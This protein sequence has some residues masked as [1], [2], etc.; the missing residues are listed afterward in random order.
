MKPASQGWRGIL[1]KSPWILVDRDGT[2]VQRRHYLLSPSDIE[3]I[4]DS[5]DA[6]EELSTLGWNIVIVTNQSPIGRGLLTEREL[7]CIHEC[8]G[9]GLAERNVYPRFF[10]HCP[11]TPEQRCSCRKPK[12]GMFYEA[13]AR[14]LEPGGAWMVGDSSTD[15]LFGRNAGLRTVLL[16]TEGR[17]PTNQATVHVESFYQALPIMIGMT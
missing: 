2:I 16:D 5:L 11:H 14:G 3:F 7:A 4:Q 8:I 6:L 13:K 17:L 10:L 15:V 12:L 1:T 9:E